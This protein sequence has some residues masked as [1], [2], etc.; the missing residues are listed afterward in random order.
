MN[1]KNWFTKTVPVK[2]Q[3][4]VLFGIAAGLVWTTLGIWLKQHT[5]VLLFVG[6]FTHVI[7]MLLFKFKAEDRP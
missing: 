3:K 5:F 1:I 4:R 2:Y 7:Y 6:W